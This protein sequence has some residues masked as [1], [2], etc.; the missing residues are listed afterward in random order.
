MSEILEEISKN[1]K[2]GEA[3]VLVKAYRYAEKAHSGQKRASG[4]DYI[5]HP[6]EV[7]KIL[8]GLGMDHYSVAAAF[9]HDVLEDTPATESEIGEEFGGEILNLLKKNRRKTL[10]RFS[11]PWRKIFA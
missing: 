2:K 3:E 1:Y 9:L 4:E 10:K 11:Y 6:V 5:I 7:A 8:M